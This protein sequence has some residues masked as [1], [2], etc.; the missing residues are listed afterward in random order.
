MTLKADLI[1]ATETWPKIAIPAA[2]GTV[3]SCPISYSKEEIAEC[4]R[5]CRKVREMDEQ[6]E[7]K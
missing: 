1:E 5:L 3:A 7:K 6:E 2:D 4:L